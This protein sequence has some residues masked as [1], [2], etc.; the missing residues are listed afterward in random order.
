VARLGILR[1]FL[2]VAGRG[3]SQLVGDVGLLAVD[4][5]V[6]G[7]GVGAQLLA[8]AAVT[9]RDL[10][11]PFGFLTCGEHVT[12]FYAR[13]GWVRVPTRHGWSGRP[14]GCRSAAAR[15]WC[16]RCTRRSPTG[17]WRARSAGNGLEV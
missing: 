8:R 15:R 13:A 1:R 11:L 5:D 4:P 12:P 2:R 3:T 14:G 16:C 10:D 17:P 6:R 7:G 9:L